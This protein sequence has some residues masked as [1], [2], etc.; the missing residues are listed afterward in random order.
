[1]FGYLKHVKRSTQR[2]PRSKILI[3]LCFV[4]TC[5]EHCQ[6][7]IR[8]FHSKEQG[9]GM[10]RRGVTQL[11]VKRKRLMIR[12]LCLNSGA[13]TVRPQRISS[14]PDI[15]QRAYPCGWLGSIYKVMSTRSPVPNNN[16]NNDKNAFRIQIITIMLDAKLF[17]PDQ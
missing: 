12:I 13:T 10:A 9:H 17:L 2:P 16:N 14:R 15:I 7:N 3:P 11:T 6:A 4:P 8:L 1:M 5:S